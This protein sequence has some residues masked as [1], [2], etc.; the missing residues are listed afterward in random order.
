M[1]PVRTVPP[2]QRPITLGEV[3]ARL[4]VLHDDDDAMIDE[5]I[6]EA[7]SKLDGYRGVLGRAIMPQTW[8]ETYD[9]WGTLRL[10][11]PDVSSATVT[12]TDASD[13][14]QMLA[15]TVL[16]QDAIGFY[17]KADGPA[18]ATDIAVTYVCQAP[19]DILPSI[20]GAICALVAMKH[21]DRD[22]SGFDCYSRAFMAQ[23][24]HIRWTGV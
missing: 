23:I 18:A 6:S 8:R 13:E 11:L 15:D 3:K 7:I 12:Y 5:M 17:I 20:K 21:D 1:N 14:T 22:G 4:R 24:D 10:A 19:E 2:E 16:K 9:A